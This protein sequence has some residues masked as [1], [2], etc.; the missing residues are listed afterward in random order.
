[1]EE[2]YSQDSRGKAPTNGAHRSCC[3]CLLLSSFLF[4]SLISPKAKAID[5]EA[6]ALLEKSRVQLQSNKNK[7]H[8][9]LKII[10]PTGEIKIREMDLQTLQSEKTFKA[11]ARMTAPVDIKG[12]SVLVVIENGE[13]Q[14]WLYLPSSKQVR[15]ISSVKKSSGLLGSEL[16]PEDL[17]PDAFKGAEAKL[18]KK[19]AKVAIVELTPKAGNSEYSKIDTTFSLET[20][21]PIKTEYFTGSTLVKRVEFLDYKAYSEHIFRAQKIHILNLVKNR[22]TDIE[23]SQIDVKANLADKNFTPQALQTSW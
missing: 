9:I 2:N 8:A 16:S 23:L 7:T 19:D 12:T 18:L 21:L 13:Q 22:G 10:E 1:M 11:M 14:Q 6:Q 3:L 4:L 17:N 5:S 15:R 20:S